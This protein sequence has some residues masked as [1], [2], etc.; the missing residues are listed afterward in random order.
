MSKIIIG[1]HG[2]ANKPH[3]K[4]LEKW[5]KQAIIEG[6]CDK[7]KPRYNFDFK[8]VYWADLIYENPLDPNIT[9]KENECYLEEPYLKA[10]ISV[11][12]GDE[13]SKLKRLLEEVIKD[14]I[15]SDTITVKLKTIYDKLLSKFFN[16]LHVYFSK[17]TTFRE[18]K[19]INVQKEVRKR[20]YDCLMEYK[21]D[22]ILLI[23]H[24]MGTI[25]TYDVLS[26]VQK[27]F[28]IDTLITIGSP[29]G[30][31]YI[32][33]RIKRESEIELS[34]YKMKTPDNICK[35]WYNFSD[36]DDLVGMN[37]N[38]SEYYS[39]ND[40]R[41]KA[42]SRHVY[43][44]YCAHGEKNPHKSFGYLR[45]PEVADIIYGFL[46]RDE[47]KVTKLINDNVNNAYHVMVNKLLNW[48]K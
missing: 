38:L 15:L 36:K 35:H 3:A 30:I 44:D 12:P 1:I 47:L 45:T 5:W 17:V 24:S 33:N 23:A 9:D 48:F 37:I 28:E 31:P 39:E 43:N 4:L 6:L 16:D 46:T 10:V 29:L 32:V 25:V 13:K 11:N 21:E 40:F 19:S 26:L 27:D 2:L 34:E 41:I 22:E 14:I 18:D 7:G 8:L 20:L 42:D